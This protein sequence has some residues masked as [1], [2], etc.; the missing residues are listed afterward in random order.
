MQSRPAGPP[1]V[2]KMLRIARGDLDSSQWRGRAAP[3]RAGRRTGE[4]RRGLIA[5]KAG[6][7]RLRHR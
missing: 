6:R 3:A 2:R 5:I 7:R 4:A 1:A